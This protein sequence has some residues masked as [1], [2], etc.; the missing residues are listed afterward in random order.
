MLDT[1]TKKKKRSQN[2]LLQTSL[3]LVW[4]AP[5]TQHMTAYCR[6]AM[7]KPSVLRVQM[8]GL[9][10]R[11]RP[12]GAAAASERSSGRTEWGRV[13][14][15]QWLRSPGTRLMSSTAAQREP[16]SL[17]KKH[18]SQTEQ[19]R[20]AQTRASTTTAC[21]GDVAHSESSDMHV[22]TCRHRLTSIHTV[23]CTGKQVNT[24]C[25]R[26]RCCCMVNFDSKREAEYVYYT[27]MKARYTLSPEL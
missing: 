21:S 8:K 5:V 20:A 6:C 22:L 11:A 27:L 9:R 25:I 15:L 12:G 10:L 18:H 23:I 7:H 13:G 1:Q 3:P 2:N 17:L 16:P 24:H 26:S 19:A 4:S 14:R